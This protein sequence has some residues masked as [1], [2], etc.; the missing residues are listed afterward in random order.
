MTQRKEKPEITTAVLP[1]ALPVFPLS[2]V[3]LMPRGKLPLNIFERRY[4]SL[5]EDALGKGRMIGLV[6]PSGEGGETVSPPALYQVG[7][8]GRITSFSETDDGR[9]LINLLG[10][11]RFRVE[12]ELP[13]TN[14]YRVV[15]PDWESYLADMGPFENPDYDRD[16]LV[17]VLRTY[18]K[19]HGVMADWQ[20]VQNTASEELLSSLAMVCPLP[21]NEKQA[22]LEAPSLHARAELLISLLEMACLRQ[23]DDEG[24]RH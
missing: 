1:E 4:L 19:T 14:G 5:V 7:C 21:P 20:V 8:A 15:K 10:V 23:N 18:F 24:A 2:G 11:C 22:L 6:Q 9:F 17:N 12:K 13:V 3:V 16:R